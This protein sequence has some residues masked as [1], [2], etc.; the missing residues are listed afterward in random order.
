MTYPFHSCWRRS[1]VDI[2]LFERPITLSVRDIYW[3]SQIVLTRKSNSTLLSCR[4]E[5]FN[6]NIR[7]IF[8]LDLNN[9]KPCKSQLSTPSEDNE[10]D[11][12]FFFESEVYIWTPNVNI[13]PKCELKARK[14]HG[15]H[16]LTTMNEI[17]FLSKQFY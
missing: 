9:W 3:R 12:D 1:C 8:F 17:R 10:N 13:L 15:T 11:D 16:A 5:N 4:L 2:V 14:K 6:A 7:S